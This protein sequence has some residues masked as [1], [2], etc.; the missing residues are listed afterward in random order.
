VQSELPQEIH[1][2]IQ[3]K[4]KRIEELKMQLGALEDEN[5]KIIDN[6]QASTEV[7]LNRIKELEEVSLG[8]RPQTA[9]ILNRIRK[10]YINIIE[11]GKFDHIKEEPQEDVKELERCANCGEMIIAS[12]MAFHTVTCYRKTVRCKVCGESIQRSIKSQHLNLWRSIQKITNAIEKDDEEELTMIL[13]HGVKVD[14]KNEEGKSLLH[15]CAEYNSKSC[16]YF[17]IS[18]GANTELTNTEG[19]TPLIV[20]IEAGNNKVATSLIELGAN[21]E[22]K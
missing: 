12:K 22:I 6:F 20:A 13:D 5:T 8:A 19:S 1:N 7:L 2:L 9:N 10:S 21:I 17:L 18:R 16:L 14:Y 4:D 11:N 3:K 15:L